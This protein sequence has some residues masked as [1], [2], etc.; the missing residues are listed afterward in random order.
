MPPVTGYLTPV[1]PGKLKGNLLRDLTA[2]KANASASIAS[3][4]KLWSSIFL[5]WIFVSKVKSF[6]IAWFFL[7]PP[8]VKIFYGLFG[9]NCKALEILLTIIFTIVAQ[10]SS[11]DNL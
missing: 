10:P 7:P 8:E 9:N 4:R 6:I 2:K 11:R 3:P 1:V 5:H